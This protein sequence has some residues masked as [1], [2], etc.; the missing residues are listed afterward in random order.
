AQAEGIHHR[1]DGAVYPRTE[2]GFE[3]AIA[4][5]EIEL[6][7]N[8][9]GVLAERLEMPV[10]VESTERAVE[11]SHAD[12]RTVVEFILGRDRVGGALDAKAEPRAHLGA[13]GVLDDRRHATRHEVRIGLDVADQ[14]VDILRAI[15]QQRGTLQ[16]PQ[17]SSPT[18][19]P[20]SRAGRLNKRG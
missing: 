10:A 11:Q 6:Q 5:I 16:R 8:L 7:R 18:T 12:A 15:L 3:Q 4:E 14:T 17:I 13:L 19:T 2:R 20:A 9:A 1:G